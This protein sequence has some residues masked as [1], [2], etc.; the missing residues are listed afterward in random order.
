MFTT[1]H[2]D[3]YTHWQSPSKWNYNSVVCVHAFVLWLVVVV[4]VVW[5]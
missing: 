5:V 2:C 1:K 3:G 4:V